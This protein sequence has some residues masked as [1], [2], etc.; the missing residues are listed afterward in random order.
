MRGFFEIPLGEERGDRLLLLAAKLFSVSS[1]QVPPDANCV[2]FI[3]IRSP[4]KVPAEFAC[5]SQQ[6][7]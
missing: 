7:E 6:P 3:A 4:L 5:L 2:L 1:H